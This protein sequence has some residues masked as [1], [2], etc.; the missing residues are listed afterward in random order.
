MLMWSTDRLNLWNPFAVTYNK[1][2]VC[3]EGGIS[4]WYPT[5]ATC[6]AIGISTAYSQKILNLIEA[7][8]DDARGKQ[9]VFDQMTQ[10][11]TGS[12]SLLPGQLQVVGNNPWSLLKGF[13][14]PDVTH[15]STFNGDITCATFMTWDACV[16]W[17][18]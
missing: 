8:K 6:T 11:M 4:N 17:N 1:P 9:A 7:Y 10:F 12:K 5:P 15:V 14:S 2:I 13:V 16:Q 3:Y 18:A